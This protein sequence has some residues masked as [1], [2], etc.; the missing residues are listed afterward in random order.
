MKFFP[1]ALLLALT[2]VGC[3]DDE[4][5]TT[6]PAACAPVDAQGR[7]IRTDDPFARQTISVGDDPEEF[8]SYIDEGSGDP[9]I[10]VHGAPSYS[11]L[12]RNIIPH[13]ADTHRAIAIDL[14]GFGDSGT[15]EGATFRYPEHQQW[16]N[17]FVDA[18]ALDNITMVVH[19]IGS[20]EG[21]FYA[22]MNPDKIKALVHLEA[23]Y[24]PIPSAD[25]LPPEASFIMSAEGQQAIVDDNWF[26]ETMMPGFI[27]RDWCPE[28]KA[29]YAAPWADPERRRVLQMVPLDLPIMGQPA[30][31][32][33]TFEQFGGYL[34]T[35]DVPKLMI[36]AD[37]GVLVQDAAPPGAPMT[38]LEIVSG[39][40]NTTVVNVGPG[41]HFLQEDHPHEIGQAISDFLDALP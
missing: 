5:E 7:E 17:H 26:I 34:A 3:S 39:F 11:Y 40:P 13:V 22:A 1:H 16:F 28:E 41:L 35:A 8:I 30:D 27:Q 21:F 6:P 25:I 33:T 31:N 4:P 38:V 19:D 24:F 37:P 9:V 14:V 36:H 2:T 23:V 20:I 29:A 32:Q 18:L 12:W 15:P 10:F